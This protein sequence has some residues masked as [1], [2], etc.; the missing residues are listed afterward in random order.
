MTGGK[1]SNVEAL[2]GFA[3][4]ATDLR[5]SLD[6]VNGRLDSVATDLAGT[7][8]GPWGESAEAGKIR[9]ALLKQ[10]ELRKDEVGQLRAALKEIGDGLAD[11][12][13]TEA[14]VDNDNADRLGSLEGG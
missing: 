5:D 7:S 14:G 11:V 6:S 13:D 2:R 4:K 3:K 12:A 9:T 8:A 10:V 1:R